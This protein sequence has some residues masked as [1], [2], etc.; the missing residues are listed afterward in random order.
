MIALVIT[1]RSSCAGSSADDGMNAH[2]G[3]PASALRAA[4]SVAV[5]SSAFSPR[6]AEFSISMRPTTS[7]PMALI[8]A[9]VLTCWRARFSSFHAPRGPL[10]SVGGLPGIWQR[11]TVIGLPTRSLNDVQSTPGCVAS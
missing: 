3:A 10:T 1:S 5:A 7:A 9:T 11:L 6:L 2:T 8:A 4:T